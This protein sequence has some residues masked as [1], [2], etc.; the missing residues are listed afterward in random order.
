MNSLTDR[1]SLSL[2]LSF[3]LSLSH[4]Q[5]GYVMRV[6]DDEFIDGSNPQISGFARYM[7]HA[8]TPNVVKYIAQVDF[9]C[10]VCVSECVCVC[11]CVRVC[12]CVSSCL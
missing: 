8:Q 4:T 10:F 12:V 11:V 1:N 7:N 5:A 3:S 9:V 2:S 6:T